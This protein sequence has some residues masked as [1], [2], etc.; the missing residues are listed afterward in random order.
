MLSSLPDLGAACVL[1]CTLPVTVAEAERSFSKLKFLGRQS[2][3]SFHN[4][5][6]LAIISIDNEAA[7]ALDLVELVDQFAAAKVRRPLNESYDK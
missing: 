7:R 4:V 5:D 1:F 6:C 2:H 3:R